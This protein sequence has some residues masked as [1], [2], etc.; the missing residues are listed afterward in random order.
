[1]AACDVVVVPSTV[2]HFARPIIEAG[3]MQKPVIASHLKPLDELVINTQTGFLLDIKNHEKWV[4]KLHTLLINKKFNQKIG[5]RAFEFCNTH[6]N[7]CDQV[8][9]VETVYGKL[10]MDTKE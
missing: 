8:K 6:F 1:M 7:V 3:F 5:E 9:K 4:E 10:L 2:G